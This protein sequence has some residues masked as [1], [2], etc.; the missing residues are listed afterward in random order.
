MNYQDILFAGFGRHVGL[1]EKRPGIMKLVAPLFHEDG[2]MV[3]IFLEARG[4]GV[5]VSDHGLSLMRLSYQYDIDTQNKEKIYRQILGENRVQED[6]GNLFIDVSAAELY[7]AVL[8]F[9]Q[10][11]AK[12]CNMGLYRR[13]V[14][15]N[16]FYET[17]DE[18]VM[19]GMQRF[20]PK[21]TML[22]LPGREELEVDYAFET[23]R[24]PA[25]LFAAKEKDSA[26]LRLIV[27]ACLEFQKA[28]LPFRSLVVHQDF[29]ALTKKDVKLV[30]SAVDKQFVS[31]D[32]FRDHGVTTLERLAA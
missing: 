14:I 12:V 5:R 32:D 17:V 4:D 26:K 3:D 28:N 30:T 9:G 7:P 24:V 27:I 25:Y 1:R 18:F 11:V 29:D 21:Q 16:L 10:T 31:M 8:H 6:G 2:D 22:P 15:A 20:H 23:G 19:S 13:E